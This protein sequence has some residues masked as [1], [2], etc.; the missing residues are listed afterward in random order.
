MQI[1]HV[2]SWTTEVGGERV[3]QDFPD[4]WVVVF[5]LETKKSRCL[6]VRGF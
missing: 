3:M 2:L 6:A 1:C 5:A 4:I